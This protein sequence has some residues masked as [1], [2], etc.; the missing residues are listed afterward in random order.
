[1]LATLWLGVA[2][3]T[4]NSSSWLSAKPS[5]SSPHLQ[6][7]HGFKGLPGI[8]SHL[9][10]ANQRQGCRNTQLEGEEPPTLRPPISPE[11]PSSPWG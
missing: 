6:L 11:A 4:G 2:P 10:R 1:M 3:D 7:G 9:P 5:A 8:L